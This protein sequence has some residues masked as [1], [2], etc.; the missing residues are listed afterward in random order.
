MM[1]WGKDVVMMSAFSLRI[2]SKDTFDDIPLD[3]PKKEDLLTP[4]YKGDAYSLD[5][6]AKAS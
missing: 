3:L 5:I 1:M 6:R 2:Y 4:R